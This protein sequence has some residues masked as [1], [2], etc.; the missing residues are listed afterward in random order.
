MTLA[1]NVDE[2]GE[3]LADAFPGAV[4]TSE[5]GSIIIE[6]KQLLQVA[7]YLKDTAGLEFNYLT[8]VTAVDYIDYF[9][10]VYRLVSMKHNQSLILKTRLYTR[11]DPTVA[12]LT[13]LWRAAYYQEREIFDLLG[14]KFEAHPDLRRLLL[15]EGFE[16]HP[17]R[18]DYL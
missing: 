15:W 3:K 10:L 1:I 14:I 9:E 12:S 6:S 7:G 2:L 18:R 4:I 8:F 11:E 13:P 16:G 17:L 5:K